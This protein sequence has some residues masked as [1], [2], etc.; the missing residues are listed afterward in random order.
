[1]SE[2]DPLFALELPGLLAADL[3]I[4]LTFALSRTLSLILSSPDFPGWLT[5]VQLDEGR[6]ASTLGFAY[7]CS[8]I[9][10]AV[11]LAARGYTI[12][13]NL[14]ARS[15]TRTALLN[16]AGFVSLC[17]LVGAAGIPPFAPLSADVIGAVIGLAVGLIAWRYS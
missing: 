8:F 5:P 11:G 3:A 15:A 17:W 16:A 12:A 6:L 4:I 7:F 13:A 14:D 9:W 10:A 2:R 1:M